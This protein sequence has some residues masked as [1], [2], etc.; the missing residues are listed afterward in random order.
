[1]EFSNVV[2]QVQYQYNDIHIQ[3]RGPG[4]YSYNAKSKGYV[5]MET[6]EQAE[7]YV[8]TGHTLYFVTA[9]ELMEQG[10]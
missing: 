5:H 7:G 6:L 8:Q 1:M 3:W 9:R 2:D 4:L 10:V